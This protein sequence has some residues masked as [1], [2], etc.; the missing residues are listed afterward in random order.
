MEDENSLNN[1]RTLEKMAKDERN[2][3]DIPEDKY[4]FNK[5][6]DIF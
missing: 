5:L 2:N 3:K 6:N 1:V 4:F